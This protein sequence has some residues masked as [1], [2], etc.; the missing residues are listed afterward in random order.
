MANPFSG[1]YAMKDSATARRD[2]AAVRAVSVK[3][4]LDPAAI[5]LSSMS[6]AWPYRSP[7]RVTLAFHAGLP[8]TSGL[9]IVIPCG[10][11][12]CAAAAAV[13]R[14]SVFSYARHV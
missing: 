14:V 10:I 11:A 13:T 6:A 1:A 2:A 3:I 5:P 9:V 8:C 7:A 12:A 4:W